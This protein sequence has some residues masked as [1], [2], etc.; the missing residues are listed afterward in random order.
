MVNFSYF[1]FVFHFKIKINFLYLKDESAF[2][3]LGSETGWLTGDIINT[4][5]KHVYENILTENQR[6]IS[7]F[8]ETDMYSILEGNIRDLNFT[9]GR[10]L[11][12]VNMKDKKKLVV[13]IN[14]TNYHWYLAI[15]NLDM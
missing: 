4:Y 9:V 5:L 6:K 15:I 2:K 7:Y 1:N 11:H 8:F 12:S 10:F 13:P 3:I 14:I